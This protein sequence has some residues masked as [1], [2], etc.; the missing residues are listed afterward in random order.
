MNRL[1]I[2]GNGFD[3]AHGLKTSYEDFLVDLMI[4]RLR[5]GIETVHDKLFNV[6]FNRQSNYTT[7][8]DWSKINSIESLITNPR[9]HINSITRSE[10]RIAQ[11]FIEIKSSFFKDIIINANWTDIEKAYFNSLINRCFTDNLN[12]KIDIYKV[13][14]LNQQ[15][16][17][18]KNLFSA[19]I[20]KINKNLDNEVLNENIIKTLKTIGFAPNEESH[21]RKMFSE[22]QELGN[23]NPNH[24]KLETLYFINFN[25]TSLLSKYVR[26]GQ[27]RS[28]SILS[29]HGTIREKDEKPDPDSI[30]FGYGDDTHEKYAELENYD[31]IELL[32]HI[33]PF[34]YPNE[35][36]YG[37]LIN[38]INETIFDVYIIGHS[39]GLSDRVLLK[40]IFEH[41]NCKAIRLFHRGTEESQFKKRIALSRHFS[42]KIS[43]RNKILDFDRKDI[44][45]GG[46]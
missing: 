29:I 30:I 5:S 46:N 28:N 2:V 41:K 33:K 34:Y 45:I 38:L 22:A 8:M 26:K 10:K 11:Y 31:N 24:E 42:D 7:L 36:H 23:R 1:V 40:T 3:L 18:L 32:K 9:I 12:Q 27:I 21:K 39:L 43:M 13:E 6:S 37:N 20:L 14:K 4:T 17:E 44:F 25:Y 19:Y 15:F 16:E 35:E